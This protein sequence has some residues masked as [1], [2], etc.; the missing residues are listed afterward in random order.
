MNDAELEFLVYRIL[1]GVLYFYF[2]NEKYELKYPDNNIRYS[3]NLIYN[4][5]INDE[6]YNDWIREENLI[7][8][9]VYLGLWNKD[10]V[11]L[12][13]ELDKKIEN[14]KVE[15][16][17]A[18]IFP[19]KQKRIRLKLSELRMQINKLNSIKNEFFTNTLE[20]YASGIKNEHII[21]HT[22]YNKNGS[23]IFNSDSKINSSYA[24]FN[25]LV[26]EVNKS[27]ISIESFKKIARSQLWR[28]FWNAS[29]DHV[30]PGPV[31]YWTDDQ[32]TLVN[33]TKM[34]DSVYEHPEC[35]AD[36]II[37][38]DDMLDGWMIVQ[39]RKNDKAKKQKNIDEMNPNLKNAGEVFLMSNDQ[40]SFENIMS[41]NDVQASMRMKEK[42][43]YITSAGTAEDYELPDVQRE[44]RNKGAELLKNRK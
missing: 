31:C 11:K 17:N 40:E 5:I 39:K 28:S 38:D 41:L 30:F 4:N 29:K 42:F 23:L 33:I 2:K 6:K 25:D 16:Y 24:N 14:Q 3:A 27:T 44:I 35:P 9:L 21:C 37:E 34:Y 26:N 13:K 22:L 7:N 19:D 8:M 36:E 1:S 43:G 18:L 15:L 20:G 32:R 10:T 12:L